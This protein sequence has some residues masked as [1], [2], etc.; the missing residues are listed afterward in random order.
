MIHLSAYCNARLAWIV[1]FAAVLL[2]PPS[3]SAPAAKADKSPALKSKAAR[4]SPEDRAIDLVQKQKEVRQ[5]S[6]LFKNGINP[7]TG[8]RPG[9]MIDNHKG[10]LYTVRV[11]EDMP[12][13]SLTFKFYDVNIKTGKVTPSP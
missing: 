5:W 11:V 6:A 2:A 8:G 3:Q 13:R 1:L 12:E 7:A 9:F 4:K 10:D